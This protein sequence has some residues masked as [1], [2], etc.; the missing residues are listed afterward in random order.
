MDPKLKNKKNIRVLVC[1][2]RDYENELAVHGI[3]GTTHK[4]LGI[5]AIIHGD[6][7][8]AD[9]FADQWARK[10]EVDVIRCPADWETHGKVAGP[11]RNLKMLRYEPDLVIAF[12]GGKGTGDMIAKAKKEGIP[13]I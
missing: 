4:T 9:S 10:N 13:I 12:P 3:L 6:A 5:Q 11:T 7:A 1:G 2:G 8:G